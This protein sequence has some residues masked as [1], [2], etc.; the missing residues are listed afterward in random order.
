[1][2]DELKSL[3]SDV[4]SELKGAAK[5]KAMSMAKDKLEELESRLNKEM[6]ESLGKHG[7]QMDGA[8]QT[9][10]CRSRRP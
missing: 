1:M 3:A 4:G 6:G 2:A 8:T 5:E 7:S 10:P 9:G